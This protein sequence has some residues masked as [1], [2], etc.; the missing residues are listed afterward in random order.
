MNTIT[1]KQA[2]LSGNMRELSV[3]EINDVNGG[4]VPVVAY[5]LW[6]AAGA[7]TSVIASEVIHHH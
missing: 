6:F 1:I 7:I 3:T 5:G 2:P 4:I